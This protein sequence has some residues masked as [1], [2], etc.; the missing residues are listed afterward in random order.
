MSKVKAARKVI[1][2]RWGT[3]T[4]KNTTVTICY[5]SRFIGFHSEQIETKT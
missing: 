1:E 4:Y 2:T 5:N 3:G